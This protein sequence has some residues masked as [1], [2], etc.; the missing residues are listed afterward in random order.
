MVAA[1]WFEVGFEALALESSLFD[2]GF[3]CSV[4]MVLVS[5]D[6]CEE[7][8]AAAFW[9]VLADLSAEDCS[10]VGVAEVVSV[11]LELVLLAL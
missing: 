9:S 3:A 6:C 1:V 4:A 8:F 2:S 11:A 5:E 10:G 7:E